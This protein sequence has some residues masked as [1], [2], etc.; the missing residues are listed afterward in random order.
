M[1]SRLLISLLAAGLVGGA[2]GAW[3]QADAGGVPGWLGA[4]GVA[5]GGGAVVVPPGVR[6]LADVAYGPAPRQRMD[7]YLPERPVNAP[8]LLMVHGGAWMLGDKAMP[9]VVNE[10]IAHWVRDRGFILVSM[11]YRFVP[12]VDPPTQARDVARAL[13]AVQAAAP[14]WGGDPSRLMLMGHSAGAHLVALLSADPAMAA[15]EGAGPWRGTVALDSA[16]LDLVGLMQRP[17]PRFYDRVFGADPAGWRAASPS[18]RLTH[19]VR[20][21]LLVCSTLRRDG[22]CEQSSAFAD[23][24]RATGGSAEVLPR[25][26]THAEIDAQLGQAGD[27]TRAVDRFIDALLAGS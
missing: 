15:Q 4:I 21:L 10:K 2:A 26:L 14:G 22:S 8:I 5:G 17:H 24:V 3:A 13:A 9:A 20:P 25:A 7:V 27:Y 23:K 12:E 18:D 6:R 16:A 11:N 1:T 19:E